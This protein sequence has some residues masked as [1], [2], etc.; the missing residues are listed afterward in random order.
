MTDEEAIRQLVARFC[1]L[2]DDRRFKEWSDLFTEDGI[3]GARTSRAEILESISGGALARNPGLRRKHTVSNVVIQ[4]TG[5]TAEAV[6]D[7]VMFDLVE[8]GG[9]SIRLGRYDDRLVR[10]PDGWLFSERRLTWL[11]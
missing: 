10:Q 4:V 9:C 11:D 2:L 6:C 8:G 7:L 1:Q 5:D 3:F